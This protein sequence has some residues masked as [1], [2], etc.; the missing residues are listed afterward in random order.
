MTVKSVQHYGAGCETD[1]T[2]CSTGQRGPDDSRR[3]S[4]LGSR[5]G[6]PSIAFP[7][8][9]NLSLR[10]VPSEVSVR[11]SG[12]M[13]LVHTGSWVEASLLSHE[14]TPPLY[15]FSPLPILPSLFSS[16][17]LRR[18]AS[19]ASLARLAARHFPP[20]IATTTRAPSPRRRRMPQP[21]EGSKGDIVSLAAGVSAESTTHRCRRRRSG[22][23]PVLARQLG[24]P[25][26]VSRDHGPVRSEPDTGQA[27]EVRGRTASTPR[28][29]L[30][31]ATA[32]VERPGF[33]ST[34]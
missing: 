13:S 29:R 25:R 18:A 31:H 15:L 9:E 28:K 1:R 16:L 22:S 14:S 19:R 23:C 3:S 21:A 33:A 32:L 26:T 30:L 20:R 27:Q 12:L 34:M 24:L 4:H 17:S 2:G 10:R 6:T 8:L 7:A 11:A 5:C